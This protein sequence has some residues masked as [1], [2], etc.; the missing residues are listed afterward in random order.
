VLE[1]S[2]AATTKRIEQN[3]SRGKIKKKIKYK[4]GQLKLITASNKFIVSV[5]DLPSAHSE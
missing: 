3:K 4:S 5:V 1:T 2:A